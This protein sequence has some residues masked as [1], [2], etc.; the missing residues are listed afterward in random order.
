MA[1]NPTLGNYDETFF[2]QE[3]L[4]QL[5]S[6]MGMASR[7]HRG[8]DEQVQ[9]KGSTI[10]LRRPGT[11]TVNNA[12]ATAED[13]VTESVSV[14]LDQWKEVKFK[15]SDKDLALSSEKIISDHVRPAAVAMA[16]HIDQALAALY[17]DIPWYT[18]MQATPTLADLTAIR[19]I[20]FD[21]KVP[22]RDDA[23]MHFMLD[24]LGEQAFLD[25]LAASGQQAN[26][27]DPALRA[28]SMGRLFGFEV[29]ANQNAPTHTSGVSADAVGAATGAAAVGDTTFDFDGVTTAGTFVA[30]D[31]FV[32]A[33]HAQR[34]V[35]TANATASGG[36]VTGA[37]FYPALK[38]AVAD[39]EVVTFFLGGTAKAQRIAFHRNAFGMA[40]APL[41]EMGNELGARIATVSDPITGISLRSRIYYQGNDSEVH[42]AL[43]VLYGLVTLDPNL[44]VRGYEP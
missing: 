37:A 4:I 11:F 34:Y 13:V 42:V 39:N 41:S 31:S 19:K 16:D 30:G 38:T 26:T 29:W 21:N 1:T 44:A 3:A 6:V 25:A 22:L 12:P 9:K 23:N 10:Q 33:G 7:V 8:V 43:D 27:Q 28:G 24:G 2:A 36:A 15:L 18:V 35:L 20:M 17:A 32:F 40:M 5:E 14:T